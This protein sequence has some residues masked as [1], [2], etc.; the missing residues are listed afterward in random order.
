MAMEMKKF[1][2]GKTR[3]Q[4]EYVFWIRK[5]FEVKLNK[6]LIIGERDVNADGVLISY[7][8]E[9]PN[10]RFIPFGDASKP[11]IAREGESS[12]QAKETRYSAVTLS[13]KPRGHSA[14]GTQTVRFAIL[15]G[16][17]ILRIACMPAFC[18]TGG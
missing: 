17:G 9:C 18:I 8:L 2:C 7:Y 13:P 4:D 10:V 12:I 3:P 14:S 15:F 5:N 1:T 16:K 6:R 11:V